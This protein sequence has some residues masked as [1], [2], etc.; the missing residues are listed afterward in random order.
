M[1]LATLSAPAAI[2][3]IRCAVGDWVVGFDLARTVGVER[4]DRLEPLDGVP[5]AVGVVRTRDGDWPVYPLGTWL[6]LDPEKSDPRR[7]QVVLIEARHGRFGLAVDRVFPVARIDRGRLLP[8]PGVVGPLAAWLIAGVVLSETG[9]LVVLDPHNLDPSAAG[10]TALPPLPDLR[11][12]AAVASAGD[13]LLL[14]AK[15][16]FPGP[17]GRPVALGVPVGMVAEVCEPGPG[18]GVPSGP[19]HLLELVEWRSSAVALVDAAVWV[20][21]PPTARTPRRAVVIRGGGT[22]LAVAAGG[23][24]RTVTADTPHVSARRSLPVRAD[25]VL[26]TF[27]TTDLTIVVPDWRKLTG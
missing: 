23:D 20:G 14:V 24:V 18:S 12:T 2:N 8:P 4:G 15:S 13:R 10:D 5:D 16:E 7:G 6:G 11:P 19:E 21:L 3:L 27:D 22:R 17:G 25:R 1:T 9:P 26:G